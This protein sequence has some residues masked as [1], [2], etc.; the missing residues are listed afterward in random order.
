MVATNDSANPESMSRD[1]KTLT[2]QSHL[3]GGHGPVVPGGTQTGQ[4]DSGP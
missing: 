1:A 4:S 2:D 3:D